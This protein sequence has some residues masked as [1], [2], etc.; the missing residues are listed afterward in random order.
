M[1]ATTTRWA[2]VNA[3]E[4]DNYPDGYY[5]PYIVEVDS[6]GICGRTIC[7]WPTLHGTW[8]NDEETGTDEM[9][10]QRAEAREIV[11]LHNAAVGM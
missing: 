9:R 3:Q 2:A 11:A 4:S 6:E 1:S 10:Q 7:A 5:P 8:I